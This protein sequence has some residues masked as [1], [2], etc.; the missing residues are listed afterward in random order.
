MVCF[1]DIVLEFIGNVKADPITVSEST[2]MPTFH[3]YFGVSGVI[4]IYDSSNLTGC[5]INC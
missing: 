4:V 5:E 2:P 1:V 3:L